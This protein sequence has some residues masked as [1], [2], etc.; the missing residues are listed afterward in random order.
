MKDG[1]GIREFCYNVG[2][3]ITVQILKEKA[4]KFFFPEGNSKYG[5]LGNM[6]LELGNYAQENIYEFRNCDGETCN[7]QEYLKSRALFAS[8]FNVYFMTTCKGEEVE[9]EKLTY[10]SDVF[11]GAQNTE[12]SGEFTNLVIAST[13]KVSKHTEEKQSPILVLKDITEKRICQ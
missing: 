13:P 4:S 7:F 12:L 1:G 11:M 6:H 9:R 8:R 5:A 10:G 2:D 3:E